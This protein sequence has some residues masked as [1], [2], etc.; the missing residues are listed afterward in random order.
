VDLVLVSPIFQTRS[1][2]RARCI[3]LFGL[4]DFCRRSTLPVGALGGINDRNR[5]AVAATDAVG[6]AAIS[7]FEGSHAGKGMM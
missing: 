5:R 4:R 3:G 7:L 1:H 2:P 6:I